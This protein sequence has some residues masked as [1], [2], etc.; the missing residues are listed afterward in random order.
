MKIRDTPGRFSALS[1]GD[2]LMIKRMRP[3]CSPQSQRGVVLLITL[4]VLAII[5][6]LAITSVRNASSSE[7]VSGNVRITELATQSAELA[8]RHCEQSLLSVLTIKNGGTSNYVT[9]FVYADILDAPAESQPP[10][11]QNKATWDSGS[12]D[13]FV[14]PLPLVNQA[15]MSKT[16]YQRPPECMVE[17]MTVMLAAA[18]GPTT[19]TTFL[20]TTRGFGPEV[21]ADDGDRTRPVG[22]E[23]WLQSQIIFNY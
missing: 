16:T 6:M 9:T 1:H 21:A 23:I 7:S 8:L 18:K 14:V 3:S 22:S 15:S 20:I 19:E 12:T 10:H 2:P 13:V 5:S 17:R 11:W 4:I